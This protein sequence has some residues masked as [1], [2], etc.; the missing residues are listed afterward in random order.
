VKPKLLFIVNQAEFFISHRL[1]IA[2]EA[3][4]QGFEVAIAS[5]GNFKL[6]EQYGFEIFPLSL[7]RNSFITIFKELF[8]IR[9]AIQSFK[10][11]CVHLVTI[12]PVLLGGILARLLKIKSVVYAISGLGFIFINKGFIA[13]FKKKLVMF[14][15]KISL[16]HKNSKV[17]FQN[18]DDKQLFLDNHLVKEK[19]IV[20]IQGSGVDLDKFQP[21][22]IENDKV[23]II[24]PA[25]MLKDKGV[26]EFVKAAQIIGN[27]KAEFILVGGLDDD[28]NPTRINEKTLNSFEG[29]SW[30]GH[31]N[32][33]QDVIKNADIVC[34]PSYREGLPKALIE[35]C[36][37]AKPIVTTNTAGCRDVVDEG[38]NGFLVKVKVVDEL[39]IALKKLIDD[40]H[41]R[42]K[43]GNLGRKKA[44]KQFSLKSVISKTI[45]IYKSF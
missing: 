38:V 5:G 20:M 13:T 17:I 4:D 3:R 33:M 6:L 18:N 25:R 45:D 44:E 32:N 40:K 39:V 15:Y 19:N 22:H 14:F 35:A 36:A 24:L 7:N 30:I 2:L 12:K 42:E 10:P 28:G 26:Y 21:F 31:K 9:N 43:F 37:C 1:P 16:G 41:L 27:E 8:L 23:R 11:T 34:L 29:V